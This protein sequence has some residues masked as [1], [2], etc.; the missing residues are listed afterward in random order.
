MFINVPFLTHIPTIYTY[1]KLKFK[2]LLA[3]Y[4]PPRMVVLDTN[5]LLVP[6]QFKINILKELDFL[7]DMEHRFVIS[8][9]TLNELRKIG[10][11]KGKN[12][13]AARLA[14]KIVENNNIDIIK[15]EMGVDDWIVSYAKET[16]AIVCTNDSA[17][18]R[19]LK[20][21]RIKV[22]AVKSRSRLGFV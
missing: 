7:I 15:N 8:S 16:G 3:M 6:F 20:P 4:M 22:V 19:R 9:R 10:K 5:F 11:S 18:R 12:G 21:L 2:G 14:V 13:V 1:E 17:L